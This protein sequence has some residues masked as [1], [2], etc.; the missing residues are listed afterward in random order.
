[1]ASGH[2]AILRARALPPNRRR[3][4]SLI[5]QPYHAEAVRFDGADL[6]DAEL[7]GADLTD[8]DFRGAKGLTRTQIHAALNAGKGAFLPVA[9]DAEAAAG[10]P[11][12]TA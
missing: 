1:M 10:T 8:A 6:T 12:G 5:Q 3:S 4:C 9:L 7:D 2:G 11:I